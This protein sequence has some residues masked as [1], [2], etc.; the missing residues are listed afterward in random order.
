MK[1]EQMA[2]DELLEQ[3]NVKAINKE[4][5][6]KEELVKVEQVEG[7]PFEI[8]EINDENGGFFFIAIGQHR[9]SEKKQTKEDCRDMIEKKNWDLIGSLCN[10][11]VK[12]F[13]T[14]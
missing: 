10:M 7:T 4:N 1:Q 12:Q 13:K 14:V 5:Y 3:P 6:S 2:G 8:V 9:L 11:I